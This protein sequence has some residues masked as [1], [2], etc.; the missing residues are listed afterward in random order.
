MKRTRPGDRVPPRQLS[1]D[2]RERFLSEP[3]FR[4]ARRQE[5]KAKVGA[6]EISKSLR[7]YR[8]DW[9]FDRSLPIP[10]VP[11]FEADLARR[12]AAKT[13]RVRPIVDAVTGKYDLLA[14]YR[15]MA[16]AYR[17]KPA[18]NFAQA[19]EKERAARTSELRQTYDQGIERMPFHAG[20]ALQKNIWLKARI[21]QLRGA[22]I[23]RFLENPQSVV[24]NEPTTVAYVA[25]AVADFGYCLRRDNGLGIRY[26]DDPEET[27]RQ[28]ALGLLRSVGADVEAAKQLEHIGLFA[29][30]GHPE[31]LIANM[32]AVKL[33]GLQQQ[34]RSDYWG[35]RLAVTVEEFG[36]VLPAVERVQ[37]IEL[38][39]LIAELYDGP[40]EQRSHAG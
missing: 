37:D 3:D 15:S 40:Q 35:E 1:A 2:D 21:A 34:I 31:F 32:E 33:T 5:D 38:V 17:N 10:P 24:D 30:D 8:R 23:G 14:P 25:D 4:E 36:E 20:D 22:Y 28:V 12:L 29:G 39:S 6:L 11:I 26:R 19:I 9:L 27:D 13:A 18:R 16:A 7:G